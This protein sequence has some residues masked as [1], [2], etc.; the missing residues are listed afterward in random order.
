MTNEFPTSDAVPRNTTAPGLW[1]VPR[2]VKQLLFTHLVVITIQIP[3]RAVL[4][5]T[6]YWRDI[7]LGVTVNLSILFVLAE[8]GRIRG[9]QF[10]LLGSL[11][12]CYVLYGVFLIPLTVYDGFTLVDSIRE[13]RNYFFP[14]VLFFVSRRILG[15]TLL[16]AQLTNLIIVMGGILIA[17]VILEYLVFM[18]GLSKNS[19]PWYAYT[20]ENSYRY[21]GNITGE[22]GYIL[23]QDSPI[24]G[25]LGWPHATVAVIMTFFAFGYPFLFSS[26]RKI[27]QVGAALWW[28]RIPNW[29]A[30]AALFA[31]I[32]GV[33]IIKVK[34][35]IVVLSFFILALPFIGTRSL[36]S[37]FWTVSCVLFLG[38]AFTLWFWPTLSDAFR[39]TFID[40]PNRRATLPVLFSSELPLFILDLPATSFFLGW[41]GDA[42]FIKDGT[43]LRL[44]YYT[45]RFGTVWLILFL[46]LFLT[47][48]WQSYRFM[49][50][51]NV[52]PF[53]R[54]YAMATSGL[55]LVCI[56]DMGHYA[57]V[58][59]WPIIDY[60][61]VCLGAMTAIADNPGG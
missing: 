19:L 57:R 43:E 34:T 7:L 26:R 55:M 1:S 39:D 49:K 30:A 33:L 27:S 44:L 58:M 20:F 22:T 6:T 11:S 21:I 56:L 35:H 32:T 50:S 8:R 24:L 9:R 31:V 41:R 36:S 52:H 46:G 3:L 12:F 54:L 60:F 47:G 61:A 10:S 40:R 48:F 59:T 13:F 5:D 53:D 28:T 51:K 18:L 29:I 16:R 15:S 2:L 4:V 38:F 45:L 25:F 17:G 23:P 42:G 14:M 37:R